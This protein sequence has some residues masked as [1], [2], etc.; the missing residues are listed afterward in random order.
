MN[1]KKSSEIVGFS[2]DAI[3]AVCERLLEKDG[4][5]ESLPGNGR[6]HNDRPLPFLVVY[7]RPAVNNDLGTEDLVSGE[8]SYLITS[9]EPNLEQAVSKLVRCLVRQL[10]K[11]FNA[12][13]I[14]EIWAVPPIQDNRDELS[15]I[16]QPKFT[17]M[18][19]GTRPPTRAIEALVKSLEAIKLNRK[20]SA[21]E[22]MYGDRRCPCNTSPLM[23]SVEARRLNC[24]IIGLE[25][26]R[27]YS[28]P[29]TGQIFPV[30]LRRF[31]RRFAHALRRG[32]FEF[33]RTH[34]TF[35][36]TNYLAL[37]KR[38]LV[39]YVLDVDRK[40]AEISNAFD[41]LLQVTPVN[42]KDA[43]ESFSQSKFNRK[44]VFYYRPLPIDP[45]FFKQKLYKI[46]LER[47]E[48]PTLAHLFRLKRRELDRQ[49][50]MLEDRETERFMYGGLQLYGKLTE[51]FVNV[52]KE[53]VLQI[54]KDKSAQMEKDLLDANQFAKKAQEEVEYYRQLYPGMTTKVE[55]REDVIGLMVS[56]G[57]LLIGWQTSI[58]ASRVN[59]LLQHEIGTH[60]VTWFN[61]KAQP[62]QQLYTGLPGYDELQEG[63][64]VLAEYLV[65]GLTGSRLRLLAGRVIAAKCL[66]DGMSFVKSF[67]ELTQTYGF[68]QR[69]AF[70]ITSR[71][72][73]GGGLIK[74][75]VYLRGLIHIL[76]YVKNGGNIEP[77]YIGKIA[78]EHIPIIEELRYRKVLRPAPL[79]PRFFKN[80]KAIERLETLR[81]GLTVLQL[82]Q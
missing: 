72:F 3:H 20:R 5:T 31:Q 33:S 32:F 37:G 4:H 19:S 26:D 18:T 69:T 68:D 63:L 25:V 21:V 47:V 6:I 43:W 61:G 30:L 67:Q 60:A 2:D 55:I 27:I 54:S 81:N 70:T 39:N 66:I 59:A 45:A 10:T 9:G 64:A 35:R 56:K 34:S 1:S 74:D 57:N 13:L 53:L 23:R 8:A 41:F 71:V 80:P 36:P 65:G 75:A 78:A 12:V 44:P 15:G 82:V 14:V 42:M 17:I 40:L 11:K 46:V 77:L 24:F 7:R 58:P 50:T 48:D 73:R 62:F 76:E 51:K 29:K 16:S 52:A 22:V 79:R 28:D 38:T 49:L